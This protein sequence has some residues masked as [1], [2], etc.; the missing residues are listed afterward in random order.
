MSSKAIERE[1]CD[2]KVSRQRI[3]FVVAALSVEVFFGCMPS[4]GFLHA[5]V[6][7]AF[8]HLTQL[9]HFNKLE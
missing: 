5:S 1:L 2:R 6:E 8:T 7:M 9:I 4:L 3:I